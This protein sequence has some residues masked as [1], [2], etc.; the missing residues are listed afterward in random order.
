MADAALPGMHDPAAAGD[1]PGR[2]GRA[3]WR[4]LAVRLLAERERWLLWV[5]VGMGLGILLYFALPVEPPGWLGTAALAAVGLAALPLRHR[6]AGLMAVAVAA[7]VLAGFAAAQLRTAAVAAPVLTAR[8]GPA[9]VTGLVVGIEAEPQGARIVLERPTVAGLAPERTPVRIRIRLRRDDVLPAAG[10]T[11]RL[12]AILNPPPAPVLPGAFDFQR[13]AFFQRLGAVG[14][15][16]DRTERLAPAAG[17]WRSAPEAVRQAVVA[18]IAA[19]LSGAEGALAAA[20]LTGERG[21]IPAP[22]LADMRAS[23]LAHLLAI[24]GLHLGLVA[25]L[26]FF[27]V[28][29]ALAAVAPLALRWPIKKIAA[30]AALLGALGYMLLV[31]APVPTQRAFLMTGLVLL[32]VLVDRAALSMRLVALAALV[33][34]ALAPESLLGASFQMSFAAVVALVAAYEALRPRWAAWRSRAG[35]GRALGLYLFG[36]A[37]TSLV[38]G[39]A[40]APFAVFHFQQAALYGLLANLLA[41]PL[42]ALWIMPCGLAGLLLMPFGLEAWALVPMGWGLGAMVEVAAAVARLPGA[43]VPVPAMPGWGLG[44]IVLGG[45]WLCLWRGRWR[46]WGVAGIALGAV[47]ATLPGPWAARPDVLVSADGRLLAVRAADGGLLL[48]TRRAARFAA[49]VWLRRDGADAAAT[50]PWPSGGAS[51]DGRLVCDPVGCLYRVEDWTVALVRERAALAE[52]CARADAVI[53]AEG[54]ARG[55]AAPIVIDRFDLRRDGAHT[56]H[57]GNRGIRVDSVGLRRGR[58]PWTG[59]PGGTGD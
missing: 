44:V 52:D 21:T 35:W 38:A 37:L 28:R 53:Y 23:G 11:V 39:L 47:C 42:T 12:R 55:C 8:H 18:R 31:G 34:L 43:S 17:S 4:A 30:L 45:L 22:V 57:L 26:I 6:T 9:T 5:P 20:L 58:R 19:V 25:G 36:V 14:F 40:T 33:V 32:A 48:S 10:S 27:T 29:A 7:M 59:T 41:V 46:L 16:L 13:H 1:P 51:A 24:S 3:L 15:A 49:Q 2:P 54:T 50:E 56:L